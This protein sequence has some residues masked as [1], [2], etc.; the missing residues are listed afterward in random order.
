MLIFIF[1]SGVPVSKFVSFKLYVA[2]LVLEKE[3]IIGICV[4]SGKDLKGKSR[5][6]IYFLKQ[7]K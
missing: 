3:M 2:D 1:C 5:L 7:Q 4:I 6:L